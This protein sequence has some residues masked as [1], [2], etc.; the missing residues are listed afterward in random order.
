VGLVFVAVAGPRGAT[1]R[2]LSL[3]G[4]RADIR[5]GTVTAVLDL[6]VDELRS[7][8]AGMHA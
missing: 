5:A 2:E 8:P 1:V 6:L 3:T 7:A 4:S